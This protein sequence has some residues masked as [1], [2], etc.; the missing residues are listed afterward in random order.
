MFHPQ[1]V[2]A[3]KVLLYWSQG[4]LLDRIRVNEWQGERGRGGPGF[5]LAARTINGA[6]DALGA[7]EES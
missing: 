3:K 4:D 2:A 6:Q 7:L 1:S 5:K